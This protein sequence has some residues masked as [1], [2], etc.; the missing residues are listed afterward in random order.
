[1]LGATA[2][3]SSSAGN[4]VGQAGHRPKI[5]YAARGLRLA[6]AVLALGLLSAAGA[7]GAVPDAQAPPAGDAA[8]QAGDSAERMVPNLP[9][10]HV[11]DAR[12]AAAGIQKLSSRRL[13]LYTDLPL[14]DEIRRLPEVFDQAFPQWCQYFRINPALHAD[15]QMTGCI[16]KD[17]ARF[18]QAGLVPADLPNFLHGYSRNYGLWLY[19]QPSVYYRRHLLLHEGTHGFMNTMLGGC[20]PPW[21]MEGTAELF[22]T[23]RLADGRLTM[24]YMPA[25]R[26]EVPEWG[27]IRIIKEAVAGHQAMQ[28]SGIVAYPAVAYLKNGPYAWSWALAAFLDGH[29]QYRDRFRQLYK[30]IPQ[31]DVSAEF[32][33]LFQPDWQELNEQWQVF[34]ADIEYG[35]DV[36]RTAIE[37]TPGRRLP[38]EGATVSVAADRGWQSSGLRLQAGDRYRLTASGRY[39]VGKSTSSLWSE[40]G[41]GSGRYEV[42]KS[43]SIWWS[44]PGGVSIRYYQGRPLGILLAAVRPDPSPADNGP[45]AFLQPIVVGLGATLS[46]QQSG[47]LLLKINHSAAE[48]ADNA[49]QLKVEVRKEE[50]RKEAARKEEVRKEGD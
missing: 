38:P 7:A 15:W 34:V 11:D 24:R 20:G 47:T 31:G 49:G 2:G 25:S 26:E 5:G 22:G 42:G 1:M 39:Q 27:R 36:G 46:P 45:S 10:L 40:P 29:P 13:V 48:L 8:A 50:V 44:E 37:F 32:H 21:Y 12:V 16:M 23:H 17:K 3:L 14:D 43:T 30:V 4:T 19:E 28:P 33:R 35:Y 41:G 6:A 9:R 18:R